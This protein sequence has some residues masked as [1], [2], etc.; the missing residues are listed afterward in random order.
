M[1]VELLTQVFDDCIEHSSFPNELKGAD[2]TFLPKNGPSNTRN[3]FRSISVLPTVS[4]L[5]ERKMDKQIVAYIH[6]FYRHFYV[7]FE[8]FIVSSM[9]L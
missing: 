2:V 9:H 5:F 1:C 4:E 8:K 7:V 3:N 6:P